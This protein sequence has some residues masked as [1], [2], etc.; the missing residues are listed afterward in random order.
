M[1]ISS[2]SV[3]ASNIYSGFSE[4]IPEHVKCLIILATSCTC[5]SIEC[6]FWDV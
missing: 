6:T 2:K 4:I 3:K 1:K 5:D